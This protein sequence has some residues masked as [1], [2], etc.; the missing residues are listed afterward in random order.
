MRRIKQYEALKFRN[1]RKKHGKDTVKIS[2]KNWEGNRET[3]AIVPVLCAIVPLFP[4]HQSKC[5]P[6][7]ISGELSEFGVLILTEEK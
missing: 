5:C 6:S 4:V 2:K 3:G 1:A 7:Y